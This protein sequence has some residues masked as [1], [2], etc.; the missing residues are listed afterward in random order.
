LAQRLIRVQRALRLVAAGGG[1]ATLSDV[2]FACGYAD[3][4]HLTREMAYFASLTPRNARDFG[5]SEDRAG[6][7]RDHARPKSSSRR[8]AVP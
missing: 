5:A 6:A 7:L 1:G 4:A 2:A 8:L 3:Q